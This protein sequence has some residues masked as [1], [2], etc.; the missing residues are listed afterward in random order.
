MTRRPGDSEARQVLARLDRFGAAAVVKTATYA[1]GSVWLSLAAGA[2]P[3]LQR[4][5]EGGG[6]W[7]GRGGAGRGGSARG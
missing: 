5:R 7:Q 2:P 3:P 6:E 4:A 1:I